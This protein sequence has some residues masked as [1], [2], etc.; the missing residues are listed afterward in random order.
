MTLSRSNSLSRTGVFD[1][2]TANKSQDEIRASLN[3]QD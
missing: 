1:D 3:R 2:W